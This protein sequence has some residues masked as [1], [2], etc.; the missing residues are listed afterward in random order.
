MTE[1]AENP[2]SP[3]DLARLARC[4]PERITRFESMGLIAPRA[5]TYERGDVT[6][7]RLLV[8]LERSGL[9]FDALADRV[10][11]GRLS[12]GFAAQ[13][14]A[15]PVGL[16][17]T[18]HAEAV[19]AQGLDPDYVSRLRLALGLPS[20]GPSDPVREDDLELYGMVAAALGAGVGEAALTRLM[21]VF[22]MGV[23]QIVEVQR[24]LFRGSVEERLL[25]GGMSYPEMLEASAPT[26]LKLQR[27]GYRTVF[28]L[29][30]RF[31][32]QAVFE[33][34][35]E[36]LEETLEEHEIGRKD[37]PERTI[38]FVDLTGY[39]RLVEA[40]GDESAAEHGARVVAIAVDVCALTG[41]RL[42]KTLGDGVMLRHDRAA[43][44]V[45]ACR[46]ILDRARE[47]GLPPAR[48]GIATGPVV[49]RDGDYFGRTVVLAARLVDVAGS[50]RILVSGSTAE[51]AGKAAG[52]V[53]DGDRRLQGIRDPVPVFV[54][55]STG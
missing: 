2:L 41:G 20:A 27:L 12:L 39:T 52:L 10:R 9:D 6:R 48:A 53:A 30:R 15:D 3:D 18:T 26:R 29:L 19:T 16:A 1:S 35:I 37:A 46:E 25:D 28:L 45:A 36:R 11:S 43:D 44:A 5:G 50:G 34:L 22:G 21:R 47:A 14:I 40:T 24:E 42:V 54:A 38:A 7:V 4:E 33:N 32:E 13:V 55:A 31:L 8:A 49:Q 17:D 51:A 23:R